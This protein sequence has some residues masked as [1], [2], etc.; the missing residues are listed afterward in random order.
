VSVSSCYI[1]FLYF[2]VYEECV[3]I[4]DAISDDADQLRSALLLR[5]RIAST[6]APYY[7]DTQRASECN[8]L[9]TCLVRVARSCTLPETLARESAVIDVSARLFLELTPSLGDQRDFVYVI[10]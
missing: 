8:E 6:I 4:A 10:S 9:A 7:A 2:I 5:L 1:H 3:D